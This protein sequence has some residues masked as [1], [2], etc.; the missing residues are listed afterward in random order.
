MDHTRPRPV[1]PGSTPAPAPSG[2]TSVYQGTLSPHFDPAATRPPSHEEVYGEASLVSGS[3]LAATQYRKSQERAINKIVQ[4]LPYQLRDSVT[5]IMNMTLS[6]S[7][8]AQKNLEISHHELI[9]MRNELH[10]KSIELE[11]AQKTLHIY[12][13]KLK[14]Q[15]ESLGMLRDDLNNK[16]VHALRNP[17]YISRL[18]STNKMLKLAQC[19][20]CG[21]ALS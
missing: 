3:T 11:T 20:G 9:D 15:N 7:E 18:S 5:A 10:K 1:L 4:K 2:K 6:A 21:T 12:R 19:S 13:E 17:K 14:G 16:A 8:I